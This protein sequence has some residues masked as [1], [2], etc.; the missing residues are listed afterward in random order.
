MA[1][2]YATPTDLS[3]WIGSVPDNVIALLR[4]ASRLV[5]KA[6]AT[7]FYAVDTNLLPTD[8]TYLQ[9]FNDATCAQAA[10]WA[11]NNIDPTTGGITTAAPIRARKIGSA[12][13]DYD[14]SV[15]SSVT[16]YAAKAFAARTL[17]EE[18]QDILQLAGIN[19][20]APW[21]AG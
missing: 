13:L 15:V 18:S 6:T 20:N 11:A 5:R 4:S 16:A 9:A 8:A 10:F 7:A 17:C 19:L 12:S 14:T 3:A 1:L 2:I 21:I